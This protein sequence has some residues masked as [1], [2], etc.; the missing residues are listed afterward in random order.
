MLKQ[1]TNR[2]T[3]DRLLQFLYVLIET[4]ENAKKFVD[5]NGIGV[6][7]E[8]LTLV[9]LQAHHIVAPLQSNLITSGPDLVL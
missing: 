2:L 4:E 7:V 8:L 3:R 9:H 5:C 1:T 6:F